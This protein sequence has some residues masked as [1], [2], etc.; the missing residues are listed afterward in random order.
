[1]IQRSDSMRL[2]PNRCP[3]TRDDAVAACGVGDR[4]RGGKLPAHVV[5]YLTMAMCLFADDDY[6][7]VAT[8]VTG[9]LSDWGAGTPGGRCRPPE[10]SHRPMTICALDLDDI[11]WDLAGSASCTSAPARAP[12]AAAPANARSR[13]AGRTLRWFIEDVWGHLDDDHTRPGAPLFPSERRNSDGSARRVGDDALRAGRAEAT[14]DG[15]A[16]VGG[17]AHP[18]R[19]A[20]LRRQPALPLGHGPDLGARTARHSWIA[21]RP[22]PRPRPPQP[23]RGR[24]GRRPATRRAPPRRRTAMK[25]NLR[26]TAATDRRDRAARR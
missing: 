13:C 5:A 16:D 6:E 3:A 24:L 11:K 14:A 26:L 7:E 4:R 19:A 22:R 10:G 9:A 18:A 8:K 2:R 1:V 15:A 21:T 23:H 17:Q 25:W 12:A 20:A